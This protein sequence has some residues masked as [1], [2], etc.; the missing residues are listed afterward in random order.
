MTRANALN[1]AAQ[2]N[3][4][5]AADIA[6][7]PSPDLGCAREERRLEAGADREQDRRHAFGEAVSPGDVTVSVDIANA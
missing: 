4:V 5:H 6:N 7:H 1:T 3:G 2:L